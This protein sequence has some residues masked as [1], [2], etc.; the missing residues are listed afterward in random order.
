VGTLFP[1]DQGPLANTEYPPAFSQS[2]LH[3]KAPLFDVLS[4]MARVCWVLLGF[5][6]MT[7]VSW[8]FAGET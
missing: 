3:V 5:P 6:Q 1:A 7:D 2:H 8:F 4:N